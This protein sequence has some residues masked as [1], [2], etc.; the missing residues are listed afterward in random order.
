MVKRG[1]RIVPLH[2]VGSRGNDFA[3]LA[4]QWPQD[5]PGACV[6]L[7]DAPY[8]FD[9]GGSGRQWFS[10]DGV[11]AA[12]RLARIVD[13]RPAFDAAIAGRDAAT[14]DLPLVLVGFSQGS[15]M[16]LDAVASGRKR[17][18]AVVAF[19]GRL[20]TPVSALQPSTPI[21]LLHGEADR[22][23]PASESAAAHQALKAA[24]FDATLRVEPGVGHAISPTG[25]RFA[26]DWLRARN[27]GEA[28]S[29]AQAPQRLLLQNP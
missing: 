18:A 25:A 24:G 13:A 29:A 21:L 27:V 15:I 8:P 9:G 7:V 23:I 14:R 28:A 6:E 19:S 10:V 26:L 5:L 2:G 1:F 17:P 12:N 20:A 16:A 11:T 4:H 22:V 3:G